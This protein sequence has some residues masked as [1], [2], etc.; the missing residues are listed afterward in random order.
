LNEHLSQ[1]SLDTKVEHQLNKIL[2]SETFRKAS[3][4]KNFLQYIVSKTLT[5]HADSLKQYTIAI[6]A[7]ARSADFDPQRDPIVRI[8][9]GRL[10]HLLSDY[11]KYE[12][13]RD[14]LIIDVPKGTYIPEFLIV[15]RL[16]SEEKGTIANNPPIIKVHP[17]QSLSSID[18]HKYVA[19]GFTEELIANLSFFKNIITVRTTPVYET[20]LEFENNKT[21]HKNDRTFYLK[22]TVRFTSTKIKVVVTLFDEVNNQPL[23]SIDFLEP[24]KVEGLIDIQ[25][26]VANKVSTSVADV[27]GGAIVKK[28]QSESTTLVYQDMDTFNLMS[29]IYQFE[30]NPDSIEYNKVLST[31]QDAIK[32]YPDFGPGWSALANLQLNN[33]A[34]GYAKEDSELLARATDYARKGVSLNPNNQFVRTI[35]GYSCLINNKL[36]DCMHQ[37]D[38]AKS[39]N[40]KSAFFLGSIGFFSSLAGKWE[41]GLEDL[42]T[43]FQLNP[44]YPSWCHVSTT[45][46]YL[47]QG[48][49]DTALEESL[50][51]DLPFILWDHVLKSVCYAYNNDITNAEIHLCKLQEVHPEFLDNPSY[52]LKMYIKFDD[53][54]KIVLK[55]LAIA[56]LEKS[57][58]T[59]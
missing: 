47:K 35:Y 30:R 59:R 45:L 39:L 41:Q 32:K 6:D 37:L 23:W 56:G 19:E 50:K 17:F 2:D 52:Y 42:A 34:L 31:F 27:Y 12:G 3:N 5:G 55:G 22:G 24:Y 29:L 8:Q 44:D 28:M 10:R 4:L 26:N 38:Y 13:E 21:K 40:P 20:T 58:F 7:F 9:A 1:T 53:I 43:S 51:I 16:S 48:A 15:E 25:V 36:E 54:L 18:E 14:T 46:Y 49:F 11:Y 33:Y 57:N